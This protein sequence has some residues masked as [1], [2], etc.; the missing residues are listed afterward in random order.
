MLV[1][2]RTFL[3]WE[4]WI[5][6]AGRALYWLLLTGSGS[7]SLGEEYVRIVPVDVRSRSLFLQKPSKRIIFA[8]LSSLL[9]IV[10][11]K[12][13]SETVDSINSVQFYWNGKFP[14]LLHWFFS[15]RYVKEREWRTRKCHPNP[16]LL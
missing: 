15:I 11:K 3:K 16:F 9:P 13:L 10:L 4:E 2:V 12:E 6:A 8:L 5:E 7:R 1:D 14:T